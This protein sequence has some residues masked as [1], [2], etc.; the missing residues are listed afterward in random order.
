MAAGMSSRFA[1]IS[2]EK[3]KALLFVKGEILLRGCQIR[4]CPM[5]SGKW[6]ND[7]YRCIWW[8]LTLGNSEICFRTAP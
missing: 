8:L 4:I 5:C 1:P 2:Y 7:Q 6:R 3:P